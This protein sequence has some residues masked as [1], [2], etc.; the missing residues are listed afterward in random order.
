M[1]RTKIVDAT[2]REGNQAPGVRF[3]VEQSVEIALQLDSLGV[4]AIEIGHPLAGPNEHERT[5]AV[6]QLGLSADILAHARAH[7]D[8]I[9]AVA[10][11]GATWVGIFLGVNDITSNSRVIGRSFEELVQ[12]ICDAVSVAKDCGLRIRYSCE[13][14][15]RTSDNFLSEAFGAAVDAGADRICYAD[16]IGHSEPS[17]I[18]KQVSLM[19]AQFPNIEAEVHL[20]DDRGLALAGALAAIDAGAEWVSASVNGLG[21]RCG[22]TELCTLLV[23]LGFRGEIELPDINVLRDISQAVAMAS[24]NPVDSMRPIVGRHAFT[25]G[26]KLHIRATSYEPRAYDWIKNYYHSLGIE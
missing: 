11:A 20:H 17:H 10:Q 18:A 26:S 2:L 9:E 4:D 12:M 14:A 13:D 5:A 22:I 1:K 6:A 23:N 7:R 25:H 24:D 16:T 19:K 3:T 21:E 8:D 15:S